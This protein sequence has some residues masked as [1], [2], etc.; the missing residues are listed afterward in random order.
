M[1]DIDELLK[2]VKESA[3]KRT[4]EER[5]QLLIDAKILTE[6]GI[7]HPDFFSEETVESSKK[8]V[9]IEKMKK[10]HKEKSLINKKTKSCDQK[11]SKKKRL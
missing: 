9:E 7:F 10:C 8:A 4:D 6:E 2:K 5:R 3:L 11:K 1:F